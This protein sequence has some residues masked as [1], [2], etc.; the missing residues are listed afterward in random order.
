M[1]VS[2]IGGGNRRKHLTCRKS[3]S[4]IRTHNF[5]GNRRISCISKL[6]INPTTIRPRQPQNIIEK[7]SIILNPLIPVDMKTVI[8]FIQVIK[9]EE[10]RQGWVIVWRHV[11][12]YFSYIVAVS[13]IG[14]GNGVP[15]E[16]HRPAAG[17]W[18]TL[19]SHD[20]VS[21]IPH[22]EWGS[23]LRL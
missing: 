17:Q 9:T 14:G 18:Q 12:Q 6:V 16:N 19:R 23:N 1:V 7:L 2:F 10:K 11:Q 13:F 5:S 15:R 22:H 20:V 21:S 8:S 3:L 4:R